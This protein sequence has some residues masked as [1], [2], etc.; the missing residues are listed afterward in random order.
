ME[1]VS[2][3]SPAKHKQGKCITL[4]NTPSHRCMMH[5]HSL[6]LSSA[7]FYDWNAGG[8]KAQ[9]TNPNTRMEHG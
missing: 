6:L 3:H 4:H 9:Q 7:V 8:L 2:G 5:S 1:R